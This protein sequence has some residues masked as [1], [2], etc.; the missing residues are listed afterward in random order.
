MIEIVD[1]I[2]LYMHIYGIIYGDLSWCTSKNHHRDA[3]LGGSASFQ[4]SKIYET[5]RPGRSCIGRIF[6][7]T[8]LAR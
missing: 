7:D 6:V 5:V 8:I 2:S 4:L 3:T 1:V